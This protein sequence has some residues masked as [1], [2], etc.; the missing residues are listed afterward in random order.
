MPGNFGLR[1][2]S[3]T[4]WRAL[5][6][7]AIRTEL[8]TIGLRVARDPAGGYDRPHLEIWSRSVEH[9]LEGYFTNTPD[10]SAFDGAPTLKSR[11]FSPDLTLRSSGI[12]RF[13]CVTPAYEGAEPA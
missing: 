6:G 9:Y 1:R 4:G 7:S 8:V 13:T 11:V 2:G 12:S 3:N 5:S 10:I